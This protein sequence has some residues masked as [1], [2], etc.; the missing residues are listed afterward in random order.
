MDRPAGPQG[1]EDHL[2]AVQNEHRRSAGEVSEDE[3]A[4]H[5]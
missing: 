4:G 1:N 3:A 5:A 2:R